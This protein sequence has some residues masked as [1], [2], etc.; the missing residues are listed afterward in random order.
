MQRILC[1]K[2]IEKRRARAPAPSTATTPR[3]LK[4]RAPSRPCFDLITCSDCLSKAR[5]LA[6]PVFALFFF[7]PRHRDICCH[8]ATRACWCKWA[9]GWAA[10]CSCPVCFSAGRA[11]GGGPSKSPTRVVPVH[12]LFFPSLSHSHRPSI[13]ASWCSACVRNF[14]NPHHT[15]T[16]R[17]HP[18][19][20]IRG[21]SLR[22]LEN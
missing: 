12:F 17:V 7:I 22:V 13:G 6:G 14:H 4:V 3:V 21:A 19:Q 5:G 18:H 11:R 8:A 1:R 20:L 16:T 9:N 10:P 15:E 2:I